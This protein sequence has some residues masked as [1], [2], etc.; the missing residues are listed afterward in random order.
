VEP[1]SSFGA[2]G[3]IRTDGPRIKSPMLYQLSYRGER[4]WTLRKT[5][6]RGPGVANYLTTLSL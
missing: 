6:R 5:S 2:P 4:H 1:I 3:Q